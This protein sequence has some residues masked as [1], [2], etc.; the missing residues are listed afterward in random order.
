MNDFCNI[1]NYSFSLAE[2]DDLLDKIIVE[3]TIKSA[4]VVM[5][6]QFA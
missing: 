5:S 2:C 4:D 3:G 6:S 1:T